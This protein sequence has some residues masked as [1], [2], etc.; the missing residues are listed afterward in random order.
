[1]QG[2]I[3]YSTSKSEILEHQKQNNKNT[4]KPFQVTKTNKNFCNSK[5]E[6]SNPHLL[7]INAD[8]LESKY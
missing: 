2:G 1:M 3:S 4:I 5:I 8:P 6:G 7:D